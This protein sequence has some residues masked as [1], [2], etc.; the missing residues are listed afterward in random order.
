MTPLRTLI[1][2][3]EALA[4]RGLRMRLERHKDVEILGE[5]RNGREALASIP[6]LE[7]NLV[8]LDIQ[9]PGFDGFDVVRSLQG[10][11]MPMVIFATA[12][13]QYA[14]RAFEV[15][16]VDYILKPVDEDHL[17]RALERARDRLTGKQAVS[18]KEHL[19]DVIGEITGRA[20]AEVEQWIG[21]GTTP[22]RRYPEKI[23]IR[24]GGSTALVPARDIDW[25]DAAGDYMCVHAKG[26][27]HV[28]R[29]TMKQLEEQ[30]DPAL[31]LRVHRS[32]IVNIDRV[33][34]ISAHM[35]GEYH[36]I[37]SDNTRLKMSRG[38]K[39]RVQLLLKH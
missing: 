14:I 39:D 22:A 18:E 16:A 2:D 5:C 31:F 7:P 15:H 3:D 38:Y 28:M 24:D 21:D 11:D 35:N 25:V 20:P 8:F 34:K 4:R 13:D 37:L 17:A 12:F 23:A 30:L 29:I 27:I 19:L 36:L 10:D 1:V 26:L 9:M 6:E 33:Q 32:T